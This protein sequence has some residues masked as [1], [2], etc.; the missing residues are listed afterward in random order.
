M[1]LE[2]ALLNTPKWL[3]DKRGVNRA[4]LPIP[5]G[6]V[7]STTSYGA[8]STTNF[9][10]SVDVDGGTTG[11]TYTNQ[12][13]PALLSPW[14]MWP[15][16]KALIVANEAA[17]TNDVRYS[18]D[19]PGVIDFLGFAGQSGPSGGVY[20]CEFDVQLDGVSLTA[21]AIVVAPYTNVATYYRSVVVPL[22]G[23]MGNPEAIPLYFEDTL[24]IYGQVTH[25]GLDSYSNIIGAIVGARQV[26]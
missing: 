6:H 5:K 17:G 13:A 7:F 9:D 10:P 3:L 14:T 2:V 18:M 16:H 4:A 20:R 19:G 24:K 25:R 26:L 8:I 11:Q 22:G 12:S 15:G 23:I 1:G 21:A